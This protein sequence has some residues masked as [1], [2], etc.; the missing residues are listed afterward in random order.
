MKTKIVIEIS[1][2]WLKVVV[3]KKISV[4]PLI[5]QD[6]ATIIAALNSV[7]KQ[8][9]PG[10][11]TEVCVVLSRNKITVRRVDLPSQDTKELEQM[12]GFYLIRQIP[13]HKEDI[14]WS[15]QNL[16]FDGISNSHLILAVALKSVFHNVVSSFGPVNLFPE[17]IL[18]SSQGLVHYVSE[19]LKDKSP[20]N[21]SYM[22]L[23]IDSNYSDLIL[24]H[25]QKL[26]SSVVIAQGFDQ[27]KSEQEKERFTVELKQ[28][29]AAL[30]NEV[31][32]AKPEKIFLTG[33][34]SSLLVLIEGI[35]A[36]GPNLKA[37]YVS[38]KEYES[39][40]SS[41][42]KGISLSAILGF[43]Y[44]VA[45]EDIK[46]IVPEL[47]IKKEI[48]VKVQQL[49]ILG[50]SLV[51]ILVMLG[52]IGLTRL[53]QQQSYAALLKTK[54]Q[55]QA[56]DSKELEEIINKL[57]VAKQYTASADSAASYLYE[58]SQL[59]PS[60]IMITSF[61]WE[62][63]KALSFRGYAL[64]IPDI[65]GFANTLSRSET[66]KG[67][68]NRYTRRRKIKDKDVVDFEIV[69]K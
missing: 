43:N 40:A 26:A 65:L 25:K 41:N 18:M 37:Q 47:Q 8:N 57:K 22:I 15:Y 44:H 31:P 38:T 12:L 2:R 14:C 39:F 17:S 62:W 35:V 6:P 21:A 28:A 9:R 66:F 4:E 23:D 49:I 53:A 48:K 16:G 5:N 30:N 3:E 59:C 61:N 42:L 10:K 13:Y 7:L 64:Q 52:V 27:L 29:I 60:S 50:I 63:K 24:V 46:F 67:A 68:Q 33:A 34:A 32:E 51:F 45:K 36:M 1:E 69:V 11:D 19:A 20:V 55:D 58:L 56:K 54:V